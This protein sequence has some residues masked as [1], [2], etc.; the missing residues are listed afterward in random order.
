MGSCFLAQFSAKPCD[1]RLRLVHLIDKQ[2]LKQRGHDVGDPLTWVWAC[3]GQGY[4]NGGHHGEFDARKLQVPKAALPAGTED[5]ARR[6]RL[7]TWFDRRYP[8]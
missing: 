8:T 2:K 6:L 7:D 4:G 1:G 5:L 3:G